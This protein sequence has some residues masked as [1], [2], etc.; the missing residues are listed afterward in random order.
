MNT[1]SKEYSNLQGD[2]SG[3]GDGESRAE[4]HGP[5]EERAALRRSEALVQSLEDAHWEGLM[6]SGAS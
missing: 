4:E 1:G 3:I 5:D 6:G 2:A